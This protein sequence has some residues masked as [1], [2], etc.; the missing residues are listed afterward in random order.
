[1]LWLRGFNTE[2]VSFFSSTL[3]FPFL[4]ISGAHFTPTSVPFFISSC[5]KYNLKE[6]SPLMKIQTLFLTLNYGNIINDVI[7]TDMCNSMVKTKFGSPWKPLNF[8]YHTCGNHMKNILFF[9]SSLKHMTCTS[10]S[11]VKKVKIWVDMYHCSNI[12]I[13]FSFHILKSK[14]EIQCTIPTMFTNRITCVI[15]SYSHY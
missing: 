5:L 14:Y 8:F 7:Q 4:S 15:T 10:Q 6:Q 12:L 3:L 11:E 13:I 2:F 9:I 1:M